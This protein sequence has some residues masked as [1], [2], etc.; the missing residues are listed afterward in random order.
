M[1]KNGSSGV[2]ERFFKVKG[3]EEVTSTAPTPLKQPAPLARLRST[4][5]LAPKPD[6][7]GWGRW[8]GDWVAR[9]TR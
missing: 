8:G 6:R 1:E 3:Q 9:R 7:K 4:N 2:K 5:P